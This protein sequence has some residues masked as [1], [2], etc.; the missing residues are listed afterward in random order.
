MILAMSSNSVNI[1][2]IVSAR[3]SGVGAVVREAVVEA[4]S[5]VLA[6]IDLKEGMVGGI[7]AVWSVF[8]GGRLDCG[9]VINTD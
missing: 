9:R 1:S 6:R 2:F 3:G 7:D 4:I 8:I 5:I